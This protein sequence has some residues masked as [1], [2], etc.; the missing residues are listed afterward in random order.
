MQKCVSAE[1]DHLVR[2]VPAEVHHLGFHHLGGGLGGGPPG[3][4]GD[5]L[6]N[7]STEF[8]LFT[9]VRYGTRI[10]ELGDRWLPSHF[11]L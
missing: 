6:G 9:S 2:G 8:E 10:E 4:P 3:P 5:G 1:V 7:S 11:D